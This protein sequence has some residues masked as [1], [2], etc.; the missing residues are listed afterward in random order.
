MPPVLPQT[1]TLPMKPYRVMTK[2][3]PTGSITLSHLKIHSNVWSL[4]TDFRKLQELAL[5]SKTDSN[6]SV[7]S[8]LIRI[9]ILF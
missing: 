5:A 9:V 3:S 8:D 4:E 7:L 1:V 6:T 2:Q